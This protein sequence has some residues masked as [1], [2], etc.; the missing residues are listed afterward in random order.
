MKRAQVLVVDDK[1]SYHS[2][3]RRILPDDIGMTSALDGMQAIELMEH[4]SFDVV[5]VDVRMP[6]LGGIDL[7][8]RI[9]QRWPEV[10]VIVM[11]AY[12]TIP[13]AVR[14]MKLGAVDYLTKPFEPDEAMK[15]IERTLGHRSSSSKAVVPY[16]E[17]LAVE[18]GRA[19]R[20]YLAQLLEETHG[21]VTLAAEK[22]GIERESLHRLLKRHGLR[23]E[24]YRPK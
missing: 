22:A 16:R 19:T 18:R 14:A 20:E 4:E 23:A 12:G 17:A 1:E 6:K 24:D 10:D 9:K 3:F 8:E 2:M 21:N 13:N 5:I 15:V 11:T 7:L